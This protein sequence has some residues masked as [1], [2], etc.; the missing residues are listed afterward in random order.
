MP[1]TLMSIVLTL[2]QV[3]FTLA[4]YSGTAKDQFY[5]QFDG[6]KIA[7]TMILSLLE[8]HVSDLLDTAGSE[9]PLKA[10]KTS[11]KDKL[12]AL[13]NESEMEGL[14]VQLKD[15]NA[16]LNTMF[17][18][19][20]SDNQNRMIDMMTNQEKT[21]KSM[22]EAQN[23]LR[24]FLHDG[25][26]DKE[27]D[28]ASILSS[29]T[30]V[31]A[32]TAFEFDSIIKATAVYKRCTSRMPPHSV[33]EPS[34][35]SA[36]S[37]DVSEDASRSQSPVDL[38][39]HGRP[40]SANH[41]PINVQHQH[42]DSIEYEPDIT[43][44]D[45]RRRRSF[46]TVRKDDLLGL[47]VE[48][49]ARSASHERIKQKT[50]EMLIQCQ[51]EGPV[52]YEPDTEN[53]S[54]ASGNT[55]KVALNNPKLLQMVDDTDSYRIKEASTAD[56]DCDML[57]A[58]T[59][60]Y[61]DAQDNISREHRKKRK[62]ARSPRAFEE[63]QQNA[64]SRISAPDLG[65]RERSFETSRTPLSPALLYDEAEER[66]ELEEWFQKEHEMNEE[67]RKSL[68]KAEE[69]SELEEW[70]RKEHEKNEE[71]RKSLADTSTIPESFNE[72]R[73]A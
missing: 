61:H 72:R 25:P 11:R 45:E 19:L 40:R 46:N 66:S 69:R 21:L 41:E 1:L 51:R 54:Y 26:V 39:P 49:Q 4:E 9:M 30:S 36:M 62:E 13:Y 23:S 60:R 59:L 24:R 73:L 71:Y 50:I 2:S 31:T 33:S 56:V 64:M 70:F 44:R 6:I 48:D 29:T 43:P 27:I 22:L 38:A 20:H 3:D 42:G 47:H 63:R 67:Y 14:F 7:C 10:Q 18:Q 52:E 58:A 55:S 68:A 12:K 34:Q 57:T 5:E 53:L 16:L 32:L 17:N 8:K 37:Y 15:H 35:I 28:T 65:A